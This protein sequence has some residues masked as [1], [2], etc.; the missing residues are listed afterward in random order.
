MGQRVCTE[1]DDQ[2]GHAGLGENL[3]RVEK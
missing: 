3:K 1:H 2:S